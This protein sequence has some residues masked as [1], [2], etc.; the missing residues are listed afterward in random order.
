MINPFQLYSPDLLQALL[1]AGHRY[2]VRQTYERGSFQDAGTTQK[3]FLISHYDNASRANVHYEALVT[4]ANR[5]LYDVSD[6][7]HLEKLEIA[8]SQPA[9]FRI[10]T[11]MLL[12]P[13]KP[14]EW[15][16][17]KVRK[18]IDQKL[19]WQPGRSTGVKTNLFTQFG[20]LFLTLKS[21]IHEVKIPLS[22]V[23]C[24]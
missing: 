6:P 18:Y 17:G 12:R 23:E 3:A 7:A 2:F 5:F 1:R 22:D 16:K 4:D 8:A 19:A 20:E 11:P 15:I 9:G 14:T 10:F 24:F 21:G 13:W